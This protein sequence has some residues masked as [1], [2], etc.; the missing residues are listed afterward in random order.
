MDT[1]EDFLKGGED[2][3]IVE[4]GNPDKSMIIKAIRWE[5]E[6]TKMPPKKKLSDEQIKNFEEWVKRGAPYPET[7]K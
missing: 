4:P 7:K 2:G 1:K 6:D 5:D 3:K